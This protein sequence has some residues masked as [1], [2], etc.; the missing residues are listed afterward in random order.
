MKNTNPYHVFAGAVAGIILTILLLL[1]MKSTAQTVNDVP[2]KDIDVEYMQIVGTQKLLS[3]KVTI[4]LDFGQTTNFWK[5]TDNQIRDE[6]GKLMAFN[7]MIDALKFFS[8]YGYEF[9]AAYIVT[10]SNQN[11]YHYLLR[12]KSTK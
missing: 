2:I 5:T 10:I 11:V 6:N 12:K 7:S 4:E 3:T 1:A 9:Y 8:K